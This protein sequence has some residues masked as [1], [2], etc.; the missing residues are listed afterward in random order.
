MVKATIRD[1]VATEHGQNSRLMWE[2]IKLRIR[3]ETIRYWAR[4]KR[5]KNNILSA[6]EK[7][8]TRLELQFQISPIGEDLILIRLIK[9]DINNI[10]QEK[11]LGCIIRSKMDLQEHGEK[12]SKF[13][14]SLEKR[15]YNNKTIRRIQRSNGTITSDEKTI[16]KELHNF[17][18]KL[19]QTSHN[20]VPDFSNL[21]YLNL[22]R[23][24]IEE[25]SACEGL[26]T[27]DE[28]LN[29]L[30]TCKNNK[31]PGTDGFPSEFYKFFWE[32]IKE[33][34][35]DALNFNYVNKQLSITQRAGLITLI[36]KK[37]KDT[38]LIKNWRP[39]TLLNQDYKLSTKAIAKR[40]CTVLPKLIH[41]D[42]T[43]F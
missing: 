5:S 16:L 1:T 37:D 39:I 33:Y 26:L 36:P 43:G 10:L 15:N 12:P 20:H 9:S 6:L 34:L 8:L 7:R 13:F 27:Q 18:N 32:D 19:Y 22:P 21:D 14:L 29:I 42:Q 41:T 11:V 23:L 38:L 2:T 28:I 31:S 3:T 17:Y 4:K 24:N 30:K 35:I 40:L 25:Q